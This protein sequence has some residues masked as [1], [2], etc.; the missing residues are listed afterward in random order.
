MLE[1]SINASHQV[2]SQFI[3]TGDVMD[4]NSYG[5]ATW[6]VTSLD[7]HHDF[8]KTLTWQTKLFNAYHQRGPTVA[9]LWPPGL[10]PSGKFPDGQY[11]HP[12]LTDMRYGLDT[13]VSYA[14]IQDMT[15]IA[16][17]AAEFS[18]TSDEDHV[19]NGPDYTGVPATPF[20]ATPNRSVF[21]GYAQGDYRFFKGLKLTAGV[22]YDHYNDFGGTT[23]TRVALVY[24]YRDKAWVKGLFATA[25]RAPNYRELHATTPT[26]TGDPSVKAETIMTGELV[27]G[28]APWRELAATVS[29]FDSRVTDLIFKYTPE[30]SKLASFQNRGNLDALG[31]EAEIKSEI[32]P[33]LE[34][35]GNY[36]YVH[37]RSSDLGNTYDTP[38]VS[39]HAANFTISR[40]LYHHVR[41]SVLGEYRSAKARY[42]LASDLSNTDPRPACGEVMLIGAYAKVYDLV[43]GVAGY[44]RVTNALDFQYQTPS[45]YPAKVAGVIPDDIHNRGIE[46][47]VG[48]TY[49]FR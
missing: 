18:T 15:L 28:F 23:N 44:L 36:T 34:L 22:R 14:P 11:G 32:L 17:G 4:S 12:Y 49:S 29:L 38:L 24:N 26:I 27:F 20:Y 33:G 13:Y 42:L 1:L 25:F 37:S 21:A 31:V 7:H 45:T 30:G 5:K 10:Q 48:L 43:E 8:S 19:S 2:N 35:A 41:L 6:I 9:L 16:G 39:H 46:I 40:D 47:Q 3:T